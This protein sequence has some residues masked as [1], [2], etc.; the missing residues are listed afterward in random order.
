[1]TIEEMI[2][3]CDEMIDLTGCAVFVNKEFFETAKEIF[4]TRLSI[5]IKRDIEPVFQNG[6]HAFDV[7]NGYYCPNCGAEINI[8]GNDK[9][10]C[11]HCGQALDWRDD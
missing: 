10:Y 4:K 2:K 1:M 5:G 8:L 9:Q 3:Y 11:P 6:Q 7:I